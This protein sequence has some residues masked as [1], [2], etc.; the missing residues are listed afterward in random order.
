MKTHKTKKIQRTGLQAPVVYSHPDNNIHKQWFDLFMKNIVEVKLIRM[1]AIG[2][3]LEITSSLSPYKK[4]GK[5]VNKILLKLWNMIFIESQKNKFKNAVNNSEMTQEQFNEEIER[6]G[7][8]EKEVET[9]NEFYS[10]TIS[11]SL[12]DSLCPKIVYYSDEYCPNGTFLKD[13]K[14]DNILHGGKTKIIAMEFMDSY[15]TLETIFEVATFEQKCLYLAMTMYTLIRF[16][17]LT[18]KRHCDEHMGNIMIDKN[19]EYFPGKLG[20]AILI[21][22]GS[23]EDMNP[24]DFNLFLLSYKEKDV[25]KLIDILKNGKN[26][27]SS[28][29]KDLIHGIETNDSETKDS[30]EWKT[31]TP[32]QNWVNEVYELIDSRGEFEDNTRS[33]ITNEITDV[34]IPP[35]EMNE[36]PDEKCRKNCGWSFNKT[37]CLTKCKTGL[38]HLEKETEF[39]E[40][41]TLHKKFCEYNGYNCW[42]R[43]NFRPNKCKIKCALNFKKLEYAKFIAHL[44]SKNPPFL[45]NKLFVQFIENSESINELRDLLNKEI[46]RLYELFGATAIQHAPNGLTTKDIILFDSLLKNFVHSDYSENIKVLKEDIEQA[47]RDMNC[48]NSVKPDMEN[49]EENPLVKSAIEGLDALNLGGFKSKKRKGKRKRKTKRFSNK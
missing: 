11:K 6:M 38:K 16:T 8:F 37:K 2:V 15:E 46:K 36:I 14:F 20:K 44:Y 22:F 24:T 9:Q 17:Y 21:D 4:N 47:K 43:R 10:K 3:A 12:D 25:G 33:K 5:V 32:F 26:C 49:L 45:C 27:F 35:P 30:D 19:V 41:A 42:S 7:L 34:E 31:L 40:L 13:F 23:T 18:G 29:I 39:I 28:H 48:V 1:G